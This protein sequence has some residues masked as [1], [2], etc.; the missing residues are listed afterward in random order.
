M[1]VPLLDLHAQHRA[2]QAQI[3]QA[4]QEVLESQQFILGPKVQAFEEA[5][6]AYLDVRHVVGVS[7]GTDALLA[8][9]WA[10][11]VGAGDRVVVPTYS[12]FATAGVV[13]RLSAR[14]LFVDIDP[15]TYNLDPKG[16]EDVVGSLPE[17]ERDRIRVILP[18]H[19]YG[20]CADMR[21]ILRVAEALGAVVVEDAA[22]AIGTQYADGRTAGSMGALGC[23]S[24]YPSK[25]LGAYGDA[26]AVVSNDPALAERVRLLRTHGA[27]PKYRHRLVGGNFRLDAIQAAVLLAKLPHLDRWTRA[28]RE[29]AQRYD[30]LFAESGL[31]ESGT[32]RTPDAV[33]RST[34]LTRDHIYHQYVIRAERRDSLRRFLADREIGTEVYYPIPLHLQ[35]CFRDLGYREGEFPAAEQ[36]ARET[37]ALPVYPELTEGQQ[38][39]VVE[40]IRDFYR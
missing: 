8:A 21:P 27:E 14:P 26:G 12:F 39:Y 15:A 23:V 25:N 24:F 17:T 30:R 40:Q 22:Q 36:A 18:V 34:G 32:V 37:L 4:I 16:L 35:E 38:A 5:L 28:R 33:Y 9:L 10:L 6:S 19:L 3:N 31:T 11:G 29:H 7:S 2:I 13:T 1:K 20:Q